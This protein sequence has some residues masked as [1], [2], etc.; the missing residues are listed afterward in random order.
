MC[1]RIEMH[2]SAVT[3]VSEDLLPVQPYV[4]FKCWDTNNEEK[5]SVSTEAKYI[6]GYLKHVPGKK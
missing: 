1:N 2:Y 3:N 4:A 6:T 5:R